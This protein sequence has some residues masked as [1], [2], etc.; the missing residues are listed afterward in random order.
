MAHDILYANSDQSGLEKQNYIFDFSPYLTGDTVLSNIASG[1]SI[2]AFN[3]SGTDVSS[4]ILSNKLRTNMLLSCDISAVVEG[5]EYRIEFAGQG[6]TTLRIQV[7][8][9]EVRARKLIQGGF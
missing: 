5:E 9:L 7:L 1:S 4:T 8:V 3:S 2:V 6:N